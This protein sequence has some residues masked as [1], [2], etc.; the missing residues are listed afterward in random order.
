MD[1]KGKF[2][3]NYTEDF[4]VACAINNLKHGDVLQYFVDKVSFYAFNG[5]EMEPLVLW[6]TDIVIDCKEAS[7]VQVTA[8]KD[9]R[10]RRTAL[11]YI[12]LLNELSEDIRLGDTDK[13]K[14]S[15]G[16]IKE[17][18]EELLPHEDYPETF[19]LEG[20]EVVKLTFD[21]CLVCRMNGLSV[22]QVLHYYMDHISLPIEKAVNIFEMVDTHPCMALFGTMMFSQ[23]EKI[24][25]IPVQQEIQKAYLERSLSLDEVLR[26]EED[27]EK[28]ISVYRSFYAEWYNALRKSIN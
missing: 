7:D 20:S 8:E 13:V 10:V 6:A 27:V 19:Q 22:P 23:S 21:F 11:K 24:K 17:W 5:G 16:V 12:L 18:A 15:A 1:S 28:R 3:L 25:R 14:Q 4:R 26:E 9:G 2:G